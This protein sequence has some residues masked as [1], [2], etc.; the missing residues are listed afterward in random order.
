MPGGQLRGTGL[1]AR[2][3]KNADDAANQRANECAK[4]R[5]DN[6]AKRNSKVLWRQIWIEY[7]DGPQTQ[8]GSDA[9]NDPQCDAS[10]EAD[11]AHAGL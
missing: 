2:T 1:P 6:D 11:V 4:D 3:A 8:V 9:D 7:G 10:T 5:S